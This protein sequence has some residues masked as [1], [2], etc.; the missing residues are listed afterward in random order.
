MNN[1]GIF[2]LK[3]ISYKIYFSLV[4]CVFFSTIDILPIGITYI[5]FGINLALSVFLLIYLVNIN[6]L[7]N[8]NFVFWLLFVFPIFISQ[9]YN[10]N[11]DPN[12][13]RFLLIVVFYPCLLFVLSYIVLRYS[14]E[15]VLSPVLISVG[16]IS[17]FSA[18]SSLG[19]YDF[20]FYGADQGLLDYYAEVY[21]RDRLLAINGVYLNQN[22]FASILLVGVFSFFINFIISKKIFT[23]VIAGFFL[24]S[25]I[26]ML[27]LTLARAAIFSTLIGF[28]FFYLF[29]NVKIHIKIIT[30]ILSLLSVSAL[31]FL[32]E[33]GFVFLEKL[34]SAGLSYRDVIWADAIQK[35]KDNLF[36]GMGLGNYQFVSGG[37]VYSTHNLYL[38]LLVSLGVIGVL[39]IFVFILFFLKKIIVMLFFSKKDKVVLIVSSSVIAILIHQLFE[40]ELDN[41]FKPFSFFFILCLAYLLSHSVEN[42]R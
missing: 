28:V 30:L 21:S 20:E 42:N 6:F 16:I 22:S 1:M 36:F 41:P 34:N 5:L 37:Q 24:L 29:S 10:V 33:Y 13:S 26:V 3:N 9:L 4:I 12:F 18:I 25:I 19:V 40:V 31:I 39:S 35:I 7:K 11:N 23:K 8:K 2:F 38:F 17:I 14:I 32:S 27:F 15:K